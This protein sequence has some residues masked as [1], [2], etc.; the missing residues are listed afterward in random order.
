V[1]AAVHSQD[2]ATVHH[3]LDRWVEFSV[4]PRT[5]GV[6]VVDAGG[7]WTLSARERVPG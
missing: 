6:G 4:F 3:W 7:T 5:T 1:T 2:H